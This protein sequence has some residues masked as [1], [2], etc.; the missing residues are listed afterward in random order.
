MVEA[1]RAGESKLTLWGTCTPRREFLYSDDLA[2]ACIHLLSLPDP[3]YDSLLSREQAPLV[4]IGT[5]EDLTVR[6]FAETV[7]RTLEFECTIVLD[8]SRPDGTPQKRLDVSRIHGLGWRARTSLEEGIRL[9]YL[10]AR[11]ELE[12]TVA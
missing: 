5:G 1:K 8:R 9:T 2:E 7:A 3:M 6:A 10:A 12:R 11:A 4:N